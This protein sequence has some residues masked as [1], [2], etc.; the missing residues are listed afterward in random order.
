MK[1]VIII[2]DSLT[3][4]NL[5]KSGF[6]NADWEVYGTSSA[7][8]GYAMVFDVA[9]DLIVTDAIMPFV[10]GFQF[11]K[12]LR[13]N[14]ETSLIP[15]IIYSILPENKAKYY[16]KED[17]V[18]Y[19]LSKDTDVDELLL[20]AEKIIKQ[21]PL[22]SDYKTGI[23]NSKSVISPIKKEITIPNKLE[24]E[25]KLNQDELE[26]KFKEKCNFDLSDE[27]IFG[28]FFGIIYPILKYDL[29]IV[30]P[31]KSY[32]QEK[33]AFFDIRNI[34]LSPIFQ[35]SVMEKYGAKDSVLYKQYAPNL[36]T[37]TNEDEFNS[38]LEF[39]IEYKN[40]PLADIVFYSL[41]K[42]KWE[43]GEN[44]EVLKKAVYNFMETY[45]IHKNEKILTLKKENSSEGY[46]SDRFNILNIQEPFSKDK[47]TYL[48]I[49][50]ISNFTD[51]ASYMSKEDTDI[52]NS[53]ISQTIIRYLT[54][55]EQVIKND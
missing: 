45:F 17:R 25:V 41:E 37:V 15:V 44:C 2:D 52:L 51:I 16:I 7:K 53:K 54:D 12:M 9:P 47:K 5:L 46:F 21:H 8:E 22:N 6:A 42:L 32:E 20:L 40:K 36:R 38:K 33:T 43:N 13:D 11:V 28:D 50:S 30:L 19:F 31:N 34:L 4:L 10:G 1:K 29:C 14:P 24:E 23:L 35:K 55:D 27:K 48:G 49:L 26:T 39:N 3:S 18:E